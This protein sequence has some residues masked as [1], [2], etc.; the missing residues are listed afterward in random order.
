[1]LFE[2]IYRTSVKKE[3][4]KLSK[5]DRAAV[6]NKIQLL[7]NNPWPVGVTKLKGYSD[8][9]RTRQGDYRLVYQVRKQVLVIIIVGVGHRRD[10]YQSL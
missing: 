2:I 1:M 10:I 4:R 8:L 5:K 6:I 7:A 9:Y 3:L